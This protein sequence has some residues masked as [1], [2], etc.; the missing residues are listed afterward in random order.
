MTE[1]SPVRDR[2]ARAKGETPAGRDRREVVLGILETLHPS[3]PR[4]GADWPED[5]SAAS[6]LGRA[7]DMLRDS[8]DCYDW[9]GFYMVDPAEPGQLVLG[10][11]SGEPTEHERIAF[12]CGVCGRAAQRLEVFLVD[13]VRS[14][15]DYLSCSPSVMSEIVVPVF[16]EGALVGE[17]DIDSHELS[18]FS[19]DDR[20]V[21]SE[22]AGRLSIL[23]QRYR[24]ENLD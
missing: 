7:C 19:G 6:L 1:S 16:H 2:G 11:Y 21:L 15:E 9:V 22:L 23:V 8:V 24:M 17:L 20:I 13:D 10:P 12:G 4:A 14:E 5:A 18:A 3:A